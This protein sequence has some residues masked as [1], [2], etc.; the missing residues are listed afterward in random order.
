MNSLASLERT[1]SHLNDSP[2]FNFEINVAVDTFATRYTR[3]HGWQG[4]GAAH[5]DL[6]GRYDD[7]TA[8]PTGGETT[9]TDYRQALRGASQRFSQV[10]SE[11][12]SLLLWF[13]DGEHATEGTS[14][15]VSRAEWEQL[16]DLCGSG[17]MR[18]VSERN[19]W[20]QAVLLSNGS[21]SDE[22]LRLLFGELL[23]NCPN[24]L[25]GEISQ[26]DAE[27]LES[28]LRELIAEAVSEVV[29][30]Q[31]TPDLLP[32]ERDSCPDPDDPPTPCTDDNSIPG[33]GTEESPCEYGF[34]LSS[35]DES[36]RLWVDLTYLN[37]GI[38]NPDKVNIRL[39]GPSG[40]QSIPLS[41][42]EDNSA[43][44]QVVAPFWFLSRR[45]YE[46][47]WEIV[48]H[49]AAEQLAQEADWEWAGEWKVLFWGDTND[50]ALDASNAAAAIRV[51]TTESPSADLSLNEK[52]S[53]VGFIQNFPQDYQS[54]EL[55][56]KLDDTEGTPVYPTRMY[57]VCKLSPCDPL[58]VN[59]EAG[60]R[61]EVPKVKDEVLWWDTD[62]AGGN[63]ERLTAAIELHGSV[64]A[65]A[66]L[67]Q[68]F[69][70]GGTD[71]FGPN[72]ERG[73]PLLWRR[74]IGSIELDLSEFLT[75]KEGVEEAKLQW[76]LLKQSI[77]EM[78]LL[79]SGLQ[80]TGPDRSPSNKVEL[81]VAVSPGYFPGVV[82]TGDVRL[83]VAD[84]ALGRLPD[85]PEW[86]CSIPG[87]S[88]R[89]GDGQGSE[90]DADCPDLNIDLG[91]SEDA[92][93]DVAV[94]FDIV[95]AAG[96]EEDLRASLTYEGACLSGRLLKRNGSTFGVPSQ[97]WHQKPPR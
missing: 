30:V 35:S 49:Q 81:E 25:D 96:L 9:L 88:D 3:H 93:V 6:I 86:S 85:V 82:T 94:S 69:L 17:A 72:G 97:R 63:G 21:P 43:G 13:T 47:R 29:C 32:G 24:N 37:R 8:L 60:H 55:Q 74:E 70:Y 75:D 46:S 64:D 56:L 33:N 36:F 4:A 22:P 28:A 61:F 65:V 1:W 77:G 23:G 58:P 10:P 2:E 87:I 31:P 40:K 39:Q 59:R 41:Y 91:L 38:R 67:E 90:I 15:D 18:L 42:A 54:V 20:T 11:G 66:T 34:I 48:G 5:L 45:L 57:L 12:C 71:G 7:I 78:A 52:G 68:K 92:I 89:R 84:Q 44:Y 83:H 76:E 19:V 73:Q 50:A 53:L 14:A 80:L 51:V 62:E 27:G 26:L 79:P 95:L 16:L